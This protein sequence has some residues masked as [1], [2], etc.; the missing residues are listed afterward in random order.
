VVRA[1]GELQKSLLLE[2]SD[3]EIHRV[4]SAGNFNAA[5]AKLLD[6]H[7]YPMKANNVGRIANDTK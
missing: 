7:G 3:L 1:V 2:F 5:M 4:L 6:D